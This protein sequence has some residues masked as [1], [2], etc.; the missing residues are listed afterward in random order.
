MYSLELSI[1]QV[2]KEILSTYKYFFLFINKKEGEKKKKKNKRRGIL[3]LFLAWMQ[4]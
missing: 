4:R 1:L 3:I 2:P